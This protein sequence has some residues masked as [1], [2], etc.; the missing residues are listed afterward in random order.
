MFEIDY[1]GLMVSMVLLAAFMMPIYLN[2]K[3][4]NK[5][6]KALVTEINKLALENGILLQNIDSWRNSYIIG[7]DPVKKKLIYISDHSEQ[8]VNIIDLSNLESVGVHSK[9]HQVGSGNES[10]KITDLLELQLHFKGGKNNSICL[11]FY[12]CDLH[13]DLQ[14][15]YPLIKK[16]H[17][18]LL[19]MKEDEKK[20]EL[21]QQ[22]TF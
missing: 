13:S 18:L 16:W 6:K 4:N 19:N 22:F 15:E 14:N 10:Y 21:K 12:D 2:V 9:N 8:N 3:K 17:Q 5:K 20:Q 1:I 11:G 7:L